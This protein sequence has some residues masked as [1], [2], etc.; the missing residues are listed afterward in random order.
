MF[1]PGTRRNLLLGVVGASATWLTYLGHDTWYNSINADDGKLKQDEKIKD[2]DKG[3][4]LEK[5]YLNSAT[6]NHKYRKVAPK[7]FE[8]LHQAKEY[9]GAPGLSYAISHNGELVMKG[10]IGL[11]DVENY[12]L[13]TSKTAMRIASI[14]KS[15]TTVAV[16]K[17]LEEGLLDLDKPIQTYIPQFPQKQFDGEDVE[18][19]LKQV[20]SHTS[21][22][23]GYFGGIKKDKAAEL[24]DK[25]KRKRATEVARYGEECLHSN[26]N[27]FMKHYDT[28]EAGLELFQDDPL[29]YKPG[30]D[31]EYSS[32]AY[33]LVSRA[34]EE[35][36]GIDYV[37]YMKKICKDIGMG[38]TRVDL[39]NTITLNRSSN[40]DRKEDRLLKNVP[41]VDNSYKWSGGGFLSNSEDLLKL[42]NM[43]LYS[44]QTD[45]G[46]LKKS[47]VATLW[48][49]E[50]ISFTKYHKDLPNKGYGLGWA[51]K[52]KEPNEK[53][54]V[55]HGGMYYC[56]DRLLFCH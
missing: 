8:L 13:I 32:L 6:I 44:A 47:T 18:I 31:Y 33:S 22:I 10:G 55:S 35:A 56:I 48:H 26:E 34:I 52:L 49:P 53:Y 9:C 28:V 25:A 11:A 19:T 21:G 15:L 16:G 54:N 36:S 51:V 45:K 1:H 30:T 12:T 39:N 3:K 20:L 41:Y 43:M 4:I 27:Y 23:R 40:Y 42:G 46:Y 38:A 29:I 50:P 37:K 5:S 2:H 24:D 17:L 7:L 14:S